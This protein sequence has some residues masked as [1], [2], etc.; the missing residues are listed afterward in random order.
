MIVTHASKGMNMPTPSGRIRIRLRTMR[1]IRSIDLAY[2]LLRIRG[3]GV[4]E[5]PT[6]IAMGSA[7]HRSVVDV[8]RR[9]E[10]V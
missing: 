8:D 9:G 4:P 1:C 6:C 3:S 10:W 5:T 7:F 2:G